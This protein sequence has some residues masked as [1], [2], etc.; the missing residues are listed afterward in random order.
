MTQDEIREFYDSP[1]EPERQVRL[2]RFLELMHKIHTGSAAPPDVFA[3]GEEQRASNSPVGPGILA[4]FQEA[5][6]ALLEINAA[7]QEDYRQLKIAQRQAA[8]RVAKTAAELL[9]EYGDKI[10]AW[11]GKKA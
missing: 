2:A 8:A 5:K 10:E 7:M 11:E 6:R 1:L 3:E 9:D 4:E